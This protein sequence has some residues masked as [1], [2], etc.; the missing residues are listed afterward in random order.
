M[1]NTDF[2]TR[3]E[4]V[5]LPIALRRLAQKQQPKRDIIDDY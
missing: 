3:R 4:P 1:P 2:Q 5:S